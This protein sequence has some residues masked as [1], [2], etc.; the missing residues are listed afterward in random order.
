[1]RRLLALGVLAAAVWGL[2]SMRRR[3]AARRVV[4]GYDDGTE[5][6]LAPGSAEHESLV[7]A[8]GEALRP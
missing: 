7:G 4:V 1:M 6:V 3:P 5:S 2:L 8:A